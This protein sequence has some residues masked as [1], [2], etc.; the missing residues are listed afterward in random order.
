VTDAVLII[1]DRPQKK[2]HCLKVIG[3]LPVED[4]EVWDVQI[5]RHIS[6]RTH[7][8]NARLWLLHTAAAKHVGCSPTDMHEEMLC[9]HFGYTEVKMPTG[10]IRRIPLKR[11][12]ERNKKEFSEFMEYVESFYISE[13]GVFLDG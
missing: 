6:R 11:S 2:A 13:L 1:V 3:K 10:V 9:E 12:S 5:G 8:Q 4:G 7:S